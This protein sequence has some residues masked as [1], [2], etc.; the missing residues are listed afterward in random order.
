MSAYGYDREFD[1]E[2]QRQKDKALNVVF[3][4]RTEEDPAAT[5]REGRPMFCT[6]DYV[7]IRRPADRE[8]TS[9][10]PVWQEW[11]K[12]GDQILTY[13]M[14]FQ[15]QYD[16]YKASQPQIVEGTPISELPRLNEAQ[17]ATLRALDVHTIEQLASLSGQPLKNLGPD[18]LSQQQAA[19]TYLNSAKGLAE[20][21]TLAAENALL[22]QSMADLAAQTAD[23]RIKFVDMSDD[24]LKDLI[25]EKTGAAPRGNPNRATLVRMVV[26]LER[27]GSVPAEAQAAA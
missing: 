15:P 18:G 9:I 1:W 4:S 23:P 7:T 5:K 6:N 10:H 11:Q 25:R 26:E 3:S 17:R 21:T 27:G 13:A 20:V 22:K 19:A 12:H 14:R 8:S 24:N 2:V 16:R